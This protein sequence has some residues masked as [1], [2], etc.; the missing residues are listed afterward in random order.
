MPEVHETAYP[1][2]KSNP[3]RRDLAEVYTPTPE[4]MA[5]AEST[6]RAGATRLGFLVTLK[7]FQRLGYFVLTREV[8]ATI[9]EHV[10][11]SLG[12]LFVPM[13][14]ASYDQ[15]SVRKA[16]VEIIRTK[17]GVKSYAASGQDVMK[18]AMSEAA[19]TK[20]R[21]EDIINASLEMLTKER[22]ELPGFNTL[23]KTARKIRGDVNTG[24]YQHILDT[25]S[26]E[27]RAKLNA[28]FAEPGFE[29]ATTAWNTL[30]LDPGS[31]TLETLK[32]HLEHYHWLVERK[33]G[34][35][36]ASFLPKAKLEQFAADADSLD[37]YHMQRLE[38]GKRTALVVALMHVKAAKVLDDLGNLFC[39]RVVA[40]H[41][42]AKRALEAYKLAH[43]DRTDELVRALKDV[44]MAYRGEGDERERFGN[45]RGVIGHRADE[46]LTQCEAHEVYADNNYR[47]FVWKSYTSDRAT[48]FRL[49]RALPLKAT[50]QD[51]GFMRVLEFL[52]SHQETKSEWLSAREIAFELAWVDEKWWPLVTGE[53]KRTAQPERLNRKHFEACVFSQLLRELKSGDICIEGSLEYADYRS[54]L[55]SNE[56]FNQTLGEF[57]EQVGLPTEPNTFVAHMKGWL[58]EL[59]LTTDLTFA[60]NDALTIIDGEPHLKKLR[61]K[62]SKRKERFWDKKFKSRMHPLTVPDSLVDVENL[63]KLTQYFGLISGYEPKME[64]PRRRYLQ[65]IFCYGCNVGPSQTA[66]SLK[67]VDR[68][69][70][71]WVNRR[72]FTEETLEHAKNHVISAYN[73]FALPS[74]WGSGRTSSADGTKWDVYEKNLLAE[75]HIRYGGYGGI[76]YYHTS[77]TYIALFSRFIPCGVFEATYILDGPV[78]DDPDLQ[79]DTIYSDTHGQSIPLFGL[80][81]LMGI[82]LM[83]R[84][85]NWRHLTFMRP[86]KGVRYE[87]IDELFTSTPD[88]D[89][90]RRFL[91]DMLRIVMSIKA[92]KISP[93]TILKRLSTYSR[94]NH[95]YQAFYELGR[96]V[97]T[98]FLLRYVADEDLRST[99]QAAMN[100][101]EQF[102][103]FLKW[104]SLSGEE[105]RT[106]DRELQQK[107]I[108]Y[109][110]LVANCQIFHNVMQLTRIV[111][112]LREEGLEVPEEVLANM[113]PYQTEHIS[114]FGE[115]C[116]D[117]LRTPPEPD[118]DFTFATHASVEPSVYENHPS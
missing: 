98:G 52:L 116:L 79:P 110:H 6:T 9:I 75:Y 24:Y 96:V 113:N 94:K 58:S 64:D 68:K 81:F 36:L 28:L 11:R 95:V 89:L 90:I 80:A 12:Y 93:S 91:P 21:L 51:A 38:A 30:K 20:E 15:S 29:A 72:H 40:I 104:L 39:R 53:K 108:K 65:A 32:S 43:Q 77:D 97:R 23:V 106:N 76:A 42:K 48:L 71:A 13:S 35:N 112:E 56:E 44:I 114:K 3:S 37:A 82:T 5:F 22:F 100:K 2:L 88:W 31:A 103:A 55:I 45:I 10:A 47:P 86:D 14:F 111:K 41:G 85:R 19:Q 117:L 34:I 87:H 69:Q 83:P 33:P 17:L 50:T 102:N 78:E 18:R 67:D 73:R 63:L 70:L 74:Y 7:T 101:S 27:E 54:Q 118:Y 57:G 60:T 109:Q 62:L 59:A 105:I 8:P 84:I 92:G 1:R 99:I 46:L 49:A 66:K 115:F 107:I 26:S 25:L 61:R 4:E 16:H